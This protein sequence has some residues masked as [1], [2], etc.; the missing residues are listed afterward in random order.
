MAH[1]PNPDRRVPL[2]DNAV[3]NR[4]RNLCNFRVADDTLG[5]AEG[6]SAGKA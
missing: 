1:G 5:T 6:T 3:H 4:Y 2:S